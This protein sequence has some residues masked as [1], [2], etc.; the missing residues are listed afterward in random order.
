MDVGVLSKF[1]P[2]WTS[3]AVPQSLLGARERP[4]LAEAKSYAGKRFIVL[5][6][7]LRRVGKTT[8]LYQLIDSLL[9]KGV[10]P[11]NVLY[12]SFDEE[13]GGID[14]VVAAYEEKVLKKRL[15]DAGSVFL[16]FDEVHKAAGWQSKVKLLYDLNPG[17]KIFLSGSA[18]ISL[19]KKSAES[20]AGRMVDVLVEPLSFSEFLEWKGVAVDAERPELSA[21]EAEPLLSDYLRK[22]GFPEMAFEDDD[23]MIRKYVKN[24]VL[25]RI[26]YQDLPQEFGLKDAEL[27]RTLLELFAKDPGMIA[28]VDSL[29]RDL[30][31][32]RIT[33]GNYIEYLRHAL[34][35]R[36]VKNL[37]GS[38]LVSSRKGRKIYP[39]NTSFCFAY[40]EDFFSDKALERVD[41]AVVAQHLRADYYYRN[42]FEVDFVQKTSRGAFPIEVKHGNANDSQVRKFMEKFNAAK[43]L[44]V[45]RDAGAPTTGEPRTMPLWLFL[46]Q[47]TERLFE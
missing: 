16:F 23:G 31:K 20:L 24:A 12:F 19:Q 13:A 21:R 22:G 14:G 29:S 11:Y 5:L 38:A 2:W 32:N 35:V 1:N 33:I 4:V 34:L 7:G 10:P 26:L 39:A 41:E 37:R 47:E 15:A 17:L 27:L 6:Y 30:G 40:R 3:G 8:M 44:V 9:K 36:E 46:L 43:G 42:S 28:N 45:A 18:S 25:D